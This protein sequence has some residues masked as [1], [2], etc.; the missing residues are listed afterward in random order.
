VKYSTE[1]FYSRIHI[2]QDN[3]REDAPI[4]EKN[5]KCRKFC[6]SFHKI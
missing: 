6:L 3:V 1:F 4:T 2:I 5:R